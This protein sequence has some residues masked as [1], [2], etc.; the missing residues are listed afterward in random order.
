ME[1]LVT[2]LDDC[3]LLSCFRM[4]L[5]N[6]LLSV[7]VLLAYTDVIALTVSSFRSG[8]SCFSMLFIASAHIGKKS[9][10]LL[11]LSADGL[12][13]NSAFMINAYLV[14]LINAYGVSWP[15]KKTDS[16]ATFLKISSNIGR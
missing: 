14:C 7:S 12:D 9:D 15:A 8:K 6:F 13:M 2:R 4:L 16:E 3:N 10:V 5:S 11:M 1:L